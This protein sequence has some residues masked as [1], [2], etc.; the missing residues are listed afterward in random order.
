MHDLP[1]V[2]DTL[3]HAS[4][5]ARLTDVDLLE[6]VEAVYEYAVWLADLGMVDFDPFADLS[7]VIAELWARGAS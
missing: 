3:Q 1:P 2:K 7:L 6:I 4:R 5:Q